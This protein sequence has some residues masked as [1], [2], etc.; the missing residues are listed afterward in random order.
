[1]TS[2][3]AISKLELLIDKTGSPYFTQS[4]YLSFLNMAQLEFLNRL[5]PDSLGGVINFELDQNVYSNLQPLIARVFCTPVVSEATSSRLSYITIDSSLS[6]YFG[7]SCETF[8]IL[9]LALDST[10]IKYAR[11]NEIYQ[12]LGNSFKRSG[13][14][15]TVTEQD[16]RIF[17]STI[18]SVTVV[19]ARFPR[20]MT[21][22]NSPIFD[23]YVMN[24]VIQ[25]A[26]QL[27]TVATRDENG[28]QLGTN[29][30]I[31]SK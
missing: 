22:G 16:L 23:D 3:D 14:V 5:V 20:I 13:Y 21:A 30:T 24:Q 26:Y 9:S 12:K 4:E 11:Q 15:Y 7:E 2:S 19:A 27:A 28:L 8:R 31:Q 10:P 29:T 1:M 18:N 17:P 25:I 6:S